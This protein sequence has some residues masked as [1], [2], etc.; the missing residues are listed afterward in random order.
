MALKTDYKDDILNIETNT[1]R[2]YTFI[3]NGDGTYSMEDV[4]DYAQ[5]GD[6][7]G[8]EDINKTNVAINILEEVLYKKESKIIRLPNG[9]K[10]Q[11][12]TVSG[13]TVPASGQLQIAVKFSEAFESQPIIF[14]EEW[15]N[16][17]IKANP[18]SNGNVDGFTMNV[19]SLTG[20][21][22]SKR[23]VNWIAIG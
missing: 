4:T 19:R 14:C 1:K 20:V 10:I 7:F 12:G 3:D 21:A 5:T 17:N 11:W 16:Y 18:A 9:M 2:K 6:I 22:Y 8:A 23:N 13:I 15:G